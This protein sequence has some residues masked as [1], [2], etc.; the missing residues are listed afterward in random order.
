[1]NQ[2]NNESL[3]NPADIPADEVPINVPTSHRQRR[4]MSING[5]TNTS[6]MNLDAPL[7]EAVALPAT[8]IESSEIRRRMPRRINLKYLIESTDGFA[9]N[10]KLQL[11]T[12]QETHEKQRIKETTNPYG[13]SDESP[14]IP[15][16]EANTT[17]PTS[18]PTTPPSMSISTNVAFRTGGLLRI[19]SPDIMALLAQPKQPISSAEIQETTNRPDASIQPKVLTKVPITDRL[20]TPNATN[21]TN[22]QRKRRHQK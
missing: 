1:M 10:S 5:C 21:W 22:H 4:F 19:L 9:Y 3:R 14:T 8:K 15:G 20:P 2:G 7:E 12:I 18:P 11:T 13:H 17:V 6:S 16:D